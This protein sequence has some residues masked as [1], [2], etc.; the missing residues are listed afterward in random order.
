MIGYPENFVEP[1]L[2]YY[3]NE[4]LAVQV[5][6][7]DTHRFTLYHTDFLPGTNQFSPIGASR[8]NIMAMRM[9]GWFGPITIEW[10]PEQPDLA[11]SRRQAIVEVLRQHGKPI[12]ADRVVIAPSPYP[13]AMGVEAAQQFR[14]HDRTQPDVSTRVSAAADRISRDG[15]TL[16]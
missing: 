10:T 6:K 16:T 9:P 7:A 11:Q 2:G 3:V 15:S 13:G 14:K 5:A 12:L 4:Q 8:F 1:P